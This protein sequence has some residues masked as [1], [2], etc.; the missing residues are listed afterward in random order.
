MN[1]QASTSGFFDFA[2]CGPR[3]SDQMSHYKVFLLASVCGRKS[4]DS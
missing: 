2:I 3:L 1:V 4:L